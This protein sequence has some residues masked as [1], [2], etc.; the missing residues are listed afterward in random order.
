MAKRR[1]ERASRRKPQRAANKSQLAAAVGRHP[2]TVRG[3]IGDARWDL[4]TEP[5]WD[6][7]QVKAW[8]A[9]HL[10]RDPVE[11]GR[12]ADRASAPPTPP[13]S[14]PGNNGHGLPP[15]TAAKLAKVHEETEKLRRQ[16]SLFDR[17]YVQRAAVERELATVIENTKSAVLAEARALVDALDAEGHLSAKSKPAATSMALDRFESLLHTFADGVNGAA[18]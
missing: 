15:L 4:P 16:N 1:R 3:W 14:P 2:K 6:I 11:V 7:A 8:M 17:I 18:D 5:P 13:G 9:R 10:T 12:D